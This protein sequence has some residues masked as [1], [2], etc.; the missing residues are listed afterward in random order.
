MTPAQ[1]FRIVHCAYCGET[2]TVPSTRGPVATYCSPSHRQAAYR[3]R[4]RAERT[5][6]PPPPR[7]VAQEIVR[8]RSV[9]AR[10]AEARSWSEARKVLADVDQGDGKGAQR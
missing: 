2:T 7:S 5:G 9:L 10:A 1:R 8:L 4:K 6:A 3:E